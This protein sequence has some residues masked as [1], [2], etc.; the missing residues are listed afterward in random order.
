[1]G[2][3]FFPA[4]AL[5]LLC[6][7]VGIT[8]THGKNSGESVT[9][10][11]API[12]ETRATVLPEAQRLWGSIASCTIKRTGV[13]VN[14]RAYFLETCALDNTSALSLYD[15][16]PTTTY[17][18]FLDERLVQLVYEFEALNDLSALRH[19]AEHDVKEIASGR[20]GLSIDKN[21]HITVFNSEIVPQIHMLAADP[22]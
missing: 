14:R 3:A 15:E 1:M 10:T 6:A 18:Y 5:S 20:H 16:V 21:G 19:R 2:K 11:E 22:E 17:Y 9:L 4:A 8:V 7:V 13:G 12:G